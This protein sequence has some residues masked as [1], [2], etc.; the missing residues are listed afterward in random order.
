MAFFQITCPICVDYFIDPRI[1]PCSHYYCEECIHR[2]AEQAG[3]DQPFSCP[4]CRSFVWLPQNDAKSFPKALSVNRMREIHTKLLQEKKPARITCS[5]HNDPLTLFCMDCNCLICGQCGSFDHKSHSYKRVVLE[6]LCNR[7]LLRKKMTPLQP[8]SKMC[9]DAAIEANVRVSQ[10]EAQNTVNTTAVHSWADVYVE[11][12]RNFER[13]FVE[14]ASTTSKQK[15]NILQ[16]QI[17][18]Y[19]AA[20]VVIDHLKEC[21]EQSVE[22]A[23]DE[24]FIASHMNLSNLV[25]IECKKLENISLDLA[26]NA[27]VGIELPSVQSLKDLC[28][29]GAKVVVLDADPA[30]C[31]V[32]LHSAQ[33]NQCTSMTLHAMYGNGTPCKKPQAVVAKVASVD[34]YVRRTKGTQRVLN[35]NVYDIYYTP[36][37]R[38]QH[39]IA[40]TVH[41]E[42][43]AGSPFIVHAKI[44]AN[45]LGLPVK[46]MKD[47]KGAYGVA[48]NAAGEILISTCEHVQVFDKHGEKARTIRN[49]FQRLRGIA[50]DTASNIFVADSAHQCVYKTD[51]NGR[52]LKVIGRRGHGNAEF[53]DPR[54]VAVIGGQVFVCDGGNHRIQVFTRD[55]AFVKSIGSNGTGNGQ[56]RYVYDVSQDEDGNLYACDYSNHRIQVFNNEGKFLFKF[57]TGQLN[58]PAGVCVSDGFVYVS[59]Y[60]NVRVSVFNKQGA[61]QRVFITGGGFFSGCSVVGV[62]QGGFVYVCDCKN[63]RVEVF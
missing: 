23:N 29:E 5:K 37:T 17:T 40:V 8:L 2:L 4:E 7:E 38:C 59:E 46:V 52:P 41:G 63:N 32:E 13:R 51:R 31:F 33:V 9:S 48:F 44:P 1:L 20:S 55:L 34:G 39:Q 27:D 60:G 61:V 21:C 35:E 11:T 26:A 12:I 3:S 16:T 53:N 10:V 14:E 6:T 22:T 49:N 50:V 25:D 36:H 28:H 47:L 43:V 62:D 57:G 19:N 56:F 30:S 54:G 18:D 24:D 45:Q 58:R 42:Q 15:I